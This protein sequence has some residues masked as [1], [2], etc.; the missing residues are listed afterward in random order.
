MEPGARQASTRR[1]TDLDDAAV[2]GS[3]VSLRD[4]VQGLA[5]NRR[6]PLP[7]GRAHDITSMKDDGTDATSQTP[8]AE[9]KNS[10]PC[11]AIRLAA[12][13]RMTGLP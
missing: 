7:I 9:R 13:R 12:T 2:R 11:A 6:A 5:G 10:W 4:D 8:L 3:V 1:R